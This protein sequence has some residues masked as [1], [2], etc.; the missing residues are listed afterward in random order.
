MGT[1]MWVLAL[2]PWG[3]CYASSWVDV[4]VAVVVASLMMVMIRYQQRAMD[5][6]A[7]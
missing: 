3:Y 4:F 6:Y 5:L 1:E 2:K 7:T